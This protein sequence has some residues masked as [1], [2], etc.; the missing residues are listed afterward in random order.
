V[1]LKALD[2]EPQCGHGFRAS[3]GVLDGSSSGVLHLPQLVV[4][5]SVIPWLTVLLTLRKSIDPKQQFLEGPDFSMI[6]QRL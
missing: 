3:G 1:T 2:V 4:V 5:I 6:V